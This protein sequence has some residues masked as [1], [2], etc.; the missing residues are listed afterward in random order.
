[1]YSIPCTGFNADI[2]M[3]WFSAARVRVRVRVSLAI[4][5]TLK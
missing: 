1:M 3:G 2:Q 4:T 5:K